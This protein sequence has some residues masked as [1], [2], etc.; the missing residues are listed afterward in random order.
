MDPIEQ[1][2]RSSHVLPNCCRRPTLSFDNV[3]RNRRLACFCTLSTV[4]FHRN[5]AAQTEFGKPLA[6]VTGQSVTDISQNVLANLG[7]N[8]KSWRSANPGRA[9]T[10]GS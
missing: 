3:V 9:R 1:P 5:Y 7:W 6:L 4:H 8:E 2:R 10:W